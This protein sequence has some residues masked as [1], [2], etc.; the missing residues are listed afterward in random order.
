MR[1]MAQVA[2]VMN[3]DK[4]IGCHTCSVTCKQTWTNRDGVEYVWFNNVETKPG[5]GYPR[6]YEDQDRWR[7]GW[8]LDRKGRLRLRSGGRLRR[9]ATIFS[10]PDLPELDDYYEPATYDFDTLISAPAGSDIPVA[11]PR[12]AITGKEMKVSGGSNWDDDLAGSPLH[13]AQDP[14]LD[15][16]TEQVRMSFE[17]T[18]MFHLPRICEHCLN[19]ACVSACPSSAMYKRVEDGIV[20][21][22]QDKCRGWRMCVSACPYKKVYVNHRTGKAEKCTFCF[23]RIEAGLP[24]VCAETCVG[25]LRYI[26]LVLYDADAVAAAA[27]VADPADLL[28]AQRSVFLDPDDPEVQ[29]A[30]RAAGIADDWIAAAQASP[31]WQLVSRHK[32]A[33][34]L[35]PEYRTLPMVWY[36]PPLS[37]VLD[38]TT[39]RGADDAD[40]DDIFH[41]ITA[42]RIPMEYL[43]SLFTAGDVDVVAGVL[44][45]LA[46]VRAHMRRRSID[47]SADSRALAGAGMSER[48]AEDLYRLLAIAK[49]SD[50]Y[51]VPKAHKEDAAELASWASGC[52]LDSPG[53]PGMGGPGGGPGGGPVVLTLQ[54]RSPS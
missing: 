25:R 26:G 3:L 12:S 35:H 48:D 23:P 27:S 2:M 50:R 44:Q 29:R 17:Q 18:F 46:A 21:V 28:D 5:V 38:A 41:T 51:V 6:R 53:G 40:A 13:A 16:M 54:R 34:P 19:P 52:S 14:N 22:D 4:C 30:A 36:I 11:R 49:M 24:T 15:A 39:S 10:N 9:L 32:V 1:V 37:P 45:K 47:G 42:L 31:I 8:E 20:L 33:L 43:A 7:G